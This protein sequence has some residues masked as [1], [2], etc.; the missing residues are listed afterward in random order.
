MTLYIK[1]MVCRR[2]ILTVAQVLEKNGITP[3]NVALGEVTLARELPPEQEKQLRADLDAYGF[4]LLDDQRRRLIEKVKTLL[5]EQIQSGELPESFS[6]VEFVSKALHRDYSA[7]SKLFSE[8]EGITMEQYF[9]LQKIEK[10]KELLVYNE[11]SLS[12][13]SFRLGY[14]SVAYLSSQFKKVTGMTPSEFKSNHSGHRH[15]LDGVHHH[16]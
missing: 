9:I 16:H 10:V 12:E 5:I 6:L 1:N 13:I 14:S 8:V 11:L 7:V 4:E 3:V 2:C 15:P